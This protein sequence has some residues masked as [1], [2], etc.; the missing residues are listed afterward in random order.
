MAYS[1]FSSYEHWQGDEKSMTANDEKNV[2]ETERSCFSVEQLELQSKAVQ[3]LVS[4]DKPQRDTEK[5]RNQ[6]G[7]WINDYKVA[8]IRIFDPF[9]KNA[10][11]G[12]KVTAKVLADK[13][14]DQTKYRRAMFKVL[15]GGKE[16]GMLLNIRIMEQI[17]K[18]QNANGSI[19]RSEM[20]VEKTGKETYKVEFHMS[21]D[22]K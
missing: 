4:D 6:L 1:Q 16:G 10:K 8:N 11:I 2:F 15:Y 3:R 17:S 9:R 19:E 20:T 7:D 22:Q 18:F 14:I 21:S 12:K 5:K 13:P